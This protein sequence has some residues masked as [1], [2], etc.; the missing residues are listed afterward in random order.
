MDFERARETMVNSQIRTIDVTDISVLASF[1]KVRR[2]A[3]VPSNWQQMAYSDKDIP[4]GEGRFLPAAGPWARLV[5]LL[6]PSPQAKILMVGCAGGY[7]AAILGELAAG[8]VAIEENEVLALES[9]RALATNIGNNIDVHVGP[10]T[11]GYSDGGL[12]DGIII[13]GAIDDLP[14]SIGQQL[15]DGG[16]LVAVIGR[17]RTAKAHLFRRHHGVISGQPVF[18][19]AL[20]SLKAFEKKQAFE[21][22]L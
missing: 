6:A 14:S 1:S 10:L 17:G 11:E 16:R 2:E 4:V 8:V 18:D 15:M 7:G 21:F 22:S 12:Y 9:R 3:Y 13:E 20:P 19:V 5:Q